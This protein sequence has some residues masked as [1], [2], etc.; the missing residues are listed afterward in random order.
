MKKIPQIFLLLSILLISLTGCEKEDPYTPPAAPQANAGNAQIVRL[1]L[2]YVDVSGTGTSDGGVIVGYLWSLVS[3]PNVPVIVSPS[4]PNTTIKGLIG[5]DYLFQFMVID[6]QGLTGVDT[7]SVK[8]MASENL[9]LTLRPA[10]NNDEVFLLGTINGAGGGQINVPEFGVAAWTINGVESAMRGALKFD[11]S[12][13]PANAVIV[14][15]KLSLYSTPNPINGNHST[16]NAGSDNIMYIERI[17]SPWISSNI[18][19]TSPPATTATNRITVPSTSLPFL[20]LTD[21]DVSL[22]VKEMIKTNN[23]NGFWLRLKDEIIYR[24]RIFS[25]SKHADATKHPKMVI[26]YKLQ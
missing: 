9:T 4:S 13:I 2:N 3:G 17:T 15:A 25:S 6:D 5:G 23:N 22:M 7:V 11:L 26:V 12:A 18:S 20:D 14:S 1:P 19:W 10:N 16:A 24:S 8:V 21:M